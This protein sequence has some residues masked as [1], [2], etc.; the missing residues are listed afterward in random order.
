MANTNVLARLHR[1]HL[2][3]EPMRLRAVDRMA[4][5]AAETPDS[6][7]IRLPAWKV[8]LTPADRARL[9]DTVRNVLV[10]RLKNDDYVFPEERAEDDDPVE[11]SLSDYRRAFGDAEAGSVF[12]EAL[13]A[14]RGLPIRSL[15]DY[16][17]DDDWYNRSTTY[18]GPLA[19]Q[20]E[21][22]RSI[23]DDINR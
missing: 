15:E 18:R 19:P 21:T 11:S 1:V 9:M 23:F 3:S 12:A 13:D 22:G 20:P 16:D 7:W 14:F 4:K 2:L 8:L 17:P 6:G 5:L 10:P